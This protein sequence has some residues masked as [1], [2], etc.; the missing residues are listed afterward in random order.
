M[1]ASVSV[2]RVQKRTEGNERTWTSEPT[3]KEV[4][5]LCVVCYAL[6]LLVLALLGNYWHLFKTFGDNQPY[7]RIAEAIRSWN[8]GLIK[9]WQFFGLP[10]VMVGFSFA[11]HTSYWTAILSLSVI[12]AFV[13]T[14]ISQRLWGWWGGGNFCGL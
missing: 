6:Y 8:F 13:A 3:L 10:Y 2:A 5:L 7:V 4:L 1:S 11:T 9:E 14:S 12:S